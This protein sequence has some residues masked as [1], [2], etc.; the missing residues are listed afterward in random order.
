[1]PDTYYAAEMLPEM[2]FGCVCARTRVRDTHKDTQ[3]R[4]HKD[5]YIIAN[6]R[7]FHTHIEI[8][9]FGWEIQSGPPPT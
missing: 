7:P 6:T 5:S 1:M 2:V 8:V 9:L 3:A 4:L